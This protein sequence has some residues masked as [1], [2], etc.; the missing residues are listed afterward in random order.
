MKRN[1]VIVLMCVVLACG[2]VLP[3]QRRPPSSTPKPSVARWEHGVFR[4]GGNYQYEWQG[5]GKRVY[6]KTLTIF[7]EKMEQYSILARLQSLRDDTQSSLEYV[8]EAEFLNYLGAEGWEL[9]DLSDRGPAGIA[10]KTFW[11]KRPKR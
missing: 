8:G 9:V 7:F 1:F 6:G 5:P 2:G 11:F 4:I 3:A 10:N